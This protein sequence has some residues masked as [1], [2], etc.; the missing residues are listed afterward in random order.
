MVPSPIPPSAPSGW[1]HTDLFRLV[2]HDGGCVA[3]VAPQFGRNTIALAFWIN[4]QWR[5][6]M[7]IGGPDALRARPTRYGCPVLFPF[8]GY[9]RN[10]RYHWCGH[11]R[12]LPIN[13]PDGR[14]HVHGFAHDRA[15]RVV[16]TEVDCIT[17]ELATLS[18]LT[19]I[20]RNAYPFDIVIRQVVKIANRQ[21]TISLEAFNRGS[22]VAPVGLGL[23]PYVDPSFL[24]CPR[25][26]HVA[27]LPGTVQRVLEGSVP[28]SELRKVISNMRT[29][30]DMEE[31]VICLT[32]LGDEASA[33]LHG[34]DGPAVQCHLDSGWNDFI[35]F[36]PADQPS[37]ALE[38]LTCSL[39]AVSLSPA[40][41]HSLPALAPNHS[42]AAALRLRMAL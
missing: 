15:W 6:L 20:E 4:H 23:H 28:T 22:E 16:D 21:L 29:L 1:E 36:A 42:T 8:P 31:P 3:W 12:A 34:V 5:H 13:G 41:G 9:A 2:D 14:S 33:S 27:R 39:S 32:D 38:P 17:L 10:A 18:D 25:Q 24:N 35:L 40:T 7:F 19:T 37:V 30:R 26:D 11:T